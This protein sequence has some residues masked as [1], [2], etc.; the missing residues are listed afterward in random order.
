VII[1]KNLQLTMKRRNKYTVKRP[2]TWTR[3][4]GSTG[5]E[6]VSEWETCRFS[7]WQSYTVVTDTASHRIRLR[8]VSL[9]AKQ[10]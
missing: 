9:H 6:I 8:G 4:N 2:T 1:S 3:W 10:N 7:R 5:R